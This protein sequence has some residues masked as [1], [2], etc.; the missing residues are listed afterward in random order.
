LKDTTLTYDGVHLTP[1]GNA[2]MAGQ[3]VEPALSLLIL[4]GS[5]RQ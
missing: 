2:K 4:A 5:S 1:A 3:L